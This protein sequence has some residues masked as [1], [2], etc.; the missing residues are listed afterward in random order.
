MPPY[1]FHSGVQ[2]ELDVFAIG[3][4]RFLSLR[5]SNYPSIHPLG[6]DTR[7]SAFPLPKH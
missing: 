6:Q 5:D 2:G 1:A 7:D 4:F 3:L